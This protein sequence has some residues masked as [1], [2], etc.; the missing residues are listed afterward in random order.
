MTHIEY[1]N[2]GSLIEE[3]EENGSSKL[4]GERIGSDVF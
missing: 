1:Q 3:E 2:Q 4:G